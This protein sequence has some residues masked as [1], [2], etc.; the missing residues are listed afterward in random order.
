MRSNRPSGT[1]ELVC[2]LRAIEFLLPED[3][4]IVSDP[5]ARGFLGPRHAAVVDVAARL[6]PRTLLALRRSGRNRGSSG[7]FVLA[8]HRAM[9]DLLVAQEGLEQVVLLG[10]GYDTRSVRLAGALE[11]ATLFEVDHPAT[12]R[13]RNALAPVVFRNA[14]RART[15]RVPIDLERESLERRLLAAGFDPARHTFWIWEGVTM[16]LDEAVIRATLTLVE[17]LSTP[18]TL[19]IFDA[20]SPPGRGPERLVRRNLPALAVRL[21]FAEPFTWRPRPD[22]VASLLREHGFAL[23]DEVEAGPLIGRYAARR[24]GLGRRAGCGLRLFTARVGGDSDP[25][26][27]DDRNPLP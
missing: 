7:A 2:R 11:G 3:Q 10:T 16:Y 13:R 26:T 4:R 9:D 25:G 17:A 21:F 27:D 5:Y 20:W 19:L 8:R 6:P 24:R 15:V 18:G 1:A 12:A 22:A 23:I 14:P